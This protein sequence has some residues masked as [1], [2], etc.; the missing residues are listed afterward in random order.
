MFQFLIMKLSKFIQFA[1]HLVNEVFNLIP[2]MMTGSGIFL[3]A[4]IF[5]KSTFH[6]LIQPKS[7]RW[8]RK[9]IMMVLKV[10]HH[11][12]YSRQDSLKLFQRRANTIIEAH[13]EVNQTLRM[14]GGGRSLKMSQHSVAI[15]THHPHHH[16]H[17]H[18]HYRHHHPTLHLNLQSCHSHHLP[19]CHHHHSHHVL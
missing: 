12:P 19:C 1:I 5:I 10:Q 4:T 3:I 14:Y 15:V 13:L 17:C 16:H 2:V 18:H 7:K 11:C 6:H 8:W 9:K